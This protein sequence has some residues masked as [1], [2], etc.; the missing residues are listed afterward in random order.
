MA[1]WEE[2]KEGREEPES[3]A[4]SADEMATSLLSVLLGIR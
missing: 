3:R 1:R 2:G 4:S